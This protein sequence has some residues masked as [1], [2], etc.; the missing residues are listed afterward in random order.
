[1]GGLLVGAETMSASLLCLMILNL[2]DVFSAATVD[3]V[4]TTEPVTEVALSVQD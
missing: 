1:M 2:F 4:H 3:P